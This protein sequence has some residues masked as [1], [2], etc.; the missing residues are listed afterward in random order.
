MTIKIKAPK[1]WGNDK[2]PGITS[3]RKE[4]EDYPVRIVRES[5]WRKLMKLMRMCELYGDLPDGIYMALDALR[6]TNDPR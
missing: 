5:D 3:D 4:F 6:G 2:Y 1:A